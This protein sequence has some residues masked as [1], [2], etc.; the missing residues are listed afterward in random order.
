MGIDVLTFWPISGFGD[1]IVTM[2]LSPILRKPLISN[3]SLG[4][5]FTCSG[6]GLQDASQ[7]KPITM[8]PPARAE[9]LIKERLLYV[10]FM[11]VICLFF[12][13]V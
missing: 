6:V 8:P 12:N 7:L 10:V 4:I 1:M 11:S 3:H 9:L 5:L 13:K 2:P